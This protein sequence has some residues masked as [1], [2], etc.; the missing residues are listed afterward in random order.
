MVVDMMWLE[1][2]GKRGSRF[3]AAAAAKPRK[4][5]ALAHLPR[6]ISVL[7]LSSWAHGHG[8]SRYLPTYLPP[9]YLGIQR[10]LSIRK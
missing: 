6:K 3:Y 8:I 9:T 2:T 1:L 4:S 7:A 5:L 10:F